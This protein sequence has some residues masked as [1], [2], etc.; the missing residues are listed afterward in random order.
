MRK[1]KIPNI[2]LILLA[3]LVIAAI[4]GIIYVI[5]ERDNLAPTGMCS[6][7]LKI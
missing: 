6:G 7:I 2:V 3:N 4:V 1:R 5:V